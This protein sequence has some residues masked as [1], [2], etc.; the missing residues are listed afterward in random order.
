MKKISFS[1]VCDL[2]ACVLRGEVTNKVMPVSMT[3]HTGLASG[4]LKKV[5]PDDITFYFNKEDILCVEYE[6]KHYKVPKQSQP[7]YIVG[8]TVAV[9]QCLRDLGY[10]AND[11]SDGNIYGLSHTLAWRMKSHV[12]ASECKNFI[13]ITGRQVK[14]P[15]CIV[16]VT[17]L[18]VP[19]QMTS[20]RTF[21]VFTNSGTV[22]RRPGKPMLL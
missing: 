16:G 5:G 20:V 8:E 13:R 14:S 9:S 7:T 2:T 10:D 4:N 18:T 15:A 17:C 11:R 12:S 19:V 22:I 6:G 1:D 21:T 3:L